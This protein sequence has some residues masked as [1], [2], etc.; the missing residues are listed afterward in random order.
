MFCTYLHVLTW[1]TVLFALHAYVTSG[2]AAVP[3]VGV[4]D[5][6]QVG[7]VTVGVPARLS[8]TVNAWLPG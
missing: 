6:S 8:L 7:Y 1:Y 4:F 3:A 5:A 2:S